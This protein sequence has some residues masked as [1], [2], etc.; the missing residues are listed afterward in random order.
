MPSFV[1]PAAMLAPSAA[2]V[3]CGMRRLFGL[4]PPYRSVTR[5]LSSSRRRS[6][7]LLNSIRRPR[8]PSW[9]HR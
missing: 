9:L 3:R 1:E 5:W 4:R 6:R 8:P 7:A 2:R